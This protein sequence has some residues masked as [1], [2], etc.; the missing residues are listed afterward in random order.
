MPDTPSYPAT[1]NASEP[2]N[3][4]RSTSASRRS[5]YLLWIVGIAVVV[6][7]VVLHLTGVLGPEGH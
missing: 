1:G 4:H 2:D 6:L 3:D 7:F 5:K